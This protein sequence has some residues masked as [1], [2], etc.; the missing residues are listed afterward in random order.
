[1]AIASNNHQFY[2]DRYERYGP[3]FKTRLFGINFVVLSGPEGFHRFIS[4]PAFERGGTDPISVKQIFLR[5]LALTDGTEHRT[6]KGV[7]LRAFQEDALEAYL[8][9]MER[10]MAAMVDK[11]EAAGELAVLPELQRMS[12]QLSGALYTSDH[13]DAHAAELD[14]LVADMRLAFSTMPVPIP[15][16]TY[17]RALKSRDRL[18]RIIDD[19]IARHKG[20]SYDDIISRMLASA[21]AEGVPH[22]KLRGD[23]LHLLFA[24]QGGFFVPLTLLTL[25]VGQH[26]DL[27]E[28]AR[29]E[30][31]A[32][33]PDGPLTMERLAGLEYLERLSRELRR[34]FAM[35]SGTFFGRVKEDVEIG[36]FRIPAGWGA[37]AAIHITMRNPA[38]WEEPERFDPDRF[39]PERVAAR[40][41]GSYVPHGEGPKTAHK[42]PAEDIVAVAVKM[43]LVHL[44]RRLKYEVPA[45]QDL[46]LKNELF[47]LPTDG[48]RVRFKRHPAA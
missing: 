41:P 34:Y 4:D 43:Y 13:S 48:L 22:E 12:A 40:R 21:T 39:L 10:I 30:I 31:L 23:L 2:K 28:K 18:I 42:C 9:R 5:S 29:E 6:R 47:P 35:N 24:S 33:V 11:F 7:M 20:G 8:P 37:I 14:K 27:M 19:A 38:V 45:D 44:L 1:L 3:I 16:T 36:G 15:G 25:V 32:K 46:S 17:G 26:P